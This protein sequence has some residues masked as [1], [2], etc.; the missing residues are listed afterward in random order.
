M[1][2]DGMVGAEQESA[3]TD[4]QTSG[5]LGRFLSVRT[6]IGFAIAVGLLVITWILADLRIEDV[7]SQIRGANP[8][9]IVAAYAVYL[10]SFPLRTLRWRILLSN[11]AH[12][13]DVKPAYRN[14][15]LFQILYISFF[16]NGIL[17]LKL[18]DFYRA[19]LARAN[20]RTSFT[21]TLGTIVAER[22]FDVATLV[23]VVV[24]AAVIILRAAEVPEEVARVIAIA[25][26]ALALLVAGLGAMLL[27][28]QPLVRRLP[29]RAQGTYDRFQSG[30]F[31]CWTWRS[32]PSLWLLSLAVWA[33]EMLRLTLVIEALGIEL[34]LAQVVF[35]GAAASLMLAVPTPGGLGAVE[36]SL[37]GLLRLVGVATPAAGAVA[38]V[39][40]FI[41]YWSV[42]LTGMIVFATA[43]LK[44]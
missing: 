7:L 29:P 18:G 36:G 13:E 38:I 24:V 33:F 27:F 23:G 22:V 34:G 25:A 12:R 15:W 10:V 39:D 4:I 5:V 43:R 3:R 19:Y 8:W 16:V 32:G 41:T 44:R 14:W 26:G 11:A 1:S 2:P 28:G 37:V 40:R 31:D 35:S 17:P 9:L 6:L 20:F 21:R 30:V 42:L